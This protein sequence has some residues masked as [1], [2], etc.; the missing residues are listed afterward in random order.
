MPIATQT[1]TERP[2][3]QYQN[4]KTAGSLKLRGNHVEPTTSA[5]PELDSKGVSLA[6]SSV[7]TVVLMCSTP[8]SKVSYQRKRLPSMSTGCTS[9]WRALGAGLTGTTGRHGVSTMSPTSTRVACITVRHYTM[10]A[11]DQVTVPAKNNSPGI[12]VPSP[13]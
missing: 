1:Q 7:A 10:C 6:R 8:S 4:P 3:P 11:D 5:Y 2:V 12:S 13:S 9:G